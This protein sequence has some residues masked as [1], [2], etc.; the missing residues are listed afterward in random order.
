MSE[1]RS[2]GHMLEGRHPRDDQVPGVSG[3][4]GKLGGG[5]LSG[6]GAGIGGGKEQGSGPFSPPTTGPSTA[7]LPTA[8]K[9]GTN[10]R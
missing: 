7:A 3:T 10:L 2:G 1:E 9:G 5:G 8:A 4:G 6:R